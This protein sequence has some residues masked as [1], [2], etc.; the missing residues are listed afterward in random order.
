LDLARI[1]QVIETS[2]IKTQCGA[3]K[4]RGCRAT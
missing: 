1:S 2:G 3:A 4:T